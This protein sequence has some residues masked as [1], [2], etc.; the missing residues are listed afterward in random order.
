MGAF[1]RKKDANLMFPIINGVVYAIAIFICSDLGGVNDELARSH[2]KPVIK[3][4]NVYQAKYHR[5]PE[6][7]GQLSPEFIDKI[8]A[9]HRMVHY[10]D[11]S[12]YLFADEPVL[13]YFSFMG[14]KRYQFKYKEWHLSD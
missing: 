8:P 13:E 9:A 6:N 12:Y 3:A 4:V 10:N 5:Y 1:F 2:A 7:L 11:F 14:M